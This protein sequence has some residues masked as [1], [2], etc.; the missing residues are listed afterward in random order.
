MSIDGPKKSRR[1]RPRVDSEPVKLRIER[2]VLNALDAYIAGNRN[3]RTR[4]TAILLLVEAALIER[5]LLEEDSARA[6]GRAYADQ[7]G[8][9]DKEFRA[10]ITR[11]RI[12]ESGIPEKEAPA[13]EPKSVVPRPPAPP[14]RSI[15][16]K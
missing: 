3:G 2:E 5:G 6:W 13:T 1:G 7:K 16:S 11:R 10:L 4:Q 12:R 14:P 15:K 8:Y 9:S